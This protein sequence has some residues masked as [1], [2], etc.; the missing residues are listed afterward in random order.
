MVVRGGGRGGFE[1]GNGELCEEERQ[2]Q[3]R[4]L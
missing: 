1:G 3:I 4:T 2:R